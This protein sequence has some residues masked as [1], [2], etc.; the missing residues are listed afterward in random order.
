MAHWKYKRGLTIIEMLIVLAVIAT[1]ATM[2]I[3]VTRRVENHAN[4]NIV[5]SAFA[6]LKAALREF[7]EDNRVFPV[8]PD[9][10]P[11][12]SS[13]IAL[14][15]IQLMYTALDNAPSCSEI[16]KG[17]DAILVHRQDTQ[18]VTTRLYDPW[19]TPFNYIY[20]P[21][22]DTFPVL[23]SA[24]PDKK[25]GTADDISSKGK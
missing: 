18:P 3:V 23:V 2:V 22:S 4:E 21:G 1:L 25:F 7:Y 15:H 17:I 24:G 20:T 16:L 14:T 19:G 5:T 11:A 12:P 8:Q 9:A 6:L 13:A 10:S